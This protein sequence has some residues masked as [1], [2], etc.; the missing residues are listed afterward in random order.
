MNE[1]EI[2]EVV[3]TKEMTLADYHRIFE[4]SKQKGWKIKAYQLEVYSPGYK[5][6]IKK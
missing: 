2:I 3:L 6:E 4:A 5:T 1:N